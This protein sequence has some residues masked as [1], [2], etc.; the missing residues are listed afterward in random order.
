M[1]SRVIRGFGMRLCAVTCCEALQCLPTRMWK[2][3]AVLFSSIHC[4]VA[5]PYIRYIDLSCSGPVSKR[6][7]RLG[8]QDKMFVLHYS[9]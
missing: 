9:T 5:A 7:R 1:I 4:L 3:D 2:D 6:N 8:T